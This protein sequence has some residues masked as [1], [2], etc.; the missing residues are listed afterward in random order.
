MTDRTQGVGR[1]GYIDPL[2]GVFEDTIDDPPPW[3]V[4]LAPVAPVTAVQAWAG[5]LR[6]WCEPVR[7][8]EWSG[9]KAN[10]TP[11]GG[12]YFSLGYDVNLE[13]AGALLSTEERT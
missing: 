12:R 1:C 11:K 8:Y 7:M 6:W 3:W 9:G 10:H 2:F 13:F 5:F 4:E